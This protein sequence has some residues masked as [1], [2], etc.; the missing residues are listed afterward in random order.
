MNSPLPKLPYSI[1][2]APGFWLTEYLLLIGWYSDILDSDLE[3]F[4]LPRTQTGK[5][6]YKYKKI[7][8]VLETWE[9]QKTPQKLTWRYLSCRAAEDAEIMF[10]ASLERAV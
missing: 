1:M 10:E 4:K 7:Q 3:L 2:V 9:I 8:E 6:I 5:Q